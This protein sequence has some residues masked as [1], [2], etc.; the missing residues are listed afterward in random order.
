MGGRWKGRKWCPTLGKIKY[1][2]EDAAT[3]A[4]ADQTE[5]YGTRF[6]PYLCSCEWWHTYSVAKGRAIDNAREPRNA[7]R[8]RSKRGE[9]P[10]GPR[11]PDP[12][13]VQR[14]VDNALARRRR[15][16]VQKSMPFFVWADD[17][18]AFHPEEGV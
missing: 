6:K 12:E 9:P 15:R 1:A 7:R 18:G 14:V 10:V 4:A 17:G 13:K 8:R 5:K 11:P 16:R 2:D 3:T